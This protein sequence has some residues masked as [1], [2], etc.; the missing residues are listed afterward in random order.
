M[1]N[2]KLTEVPKTAAYLVFQDQTLDDLMLEGKSLQTSRF[3]RLGL[4]D[5][6]IEECSLTQSL[7]ED[8]YLRKASFVNVRLTGSTFRNCNLEKATFRGC[9]LRYCTFQ[10]TRLTRDEIIGCLPVEPN[11]RLQLARNLR[12]NFEAL[13]DKASADAVLDIEIR[14]QEQELL[15]AFRRKTEYYR[16]HYTGVDQAVAGLRYLLSNLNGLVWGYGHR[17]RRLIASFA[18]LTLVFC[19][20]TYFGDVHYN[21]PTESSSRSLSFW[22]SVYQASAATVRA[23]ATAFSPASWGGRALQVLEGFTGTLL[24]ALLAA[25][26]YRRIA[27]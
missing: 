1:K 10:N 4:K 8:C 2:G 27:R 24:L 26:S 20:I 5:A 13:G 6:R 3:L 7:F 25:A 9:D 23:G 19:L 21:V 15:E 12:K 16:A 17:V 18:V 22:E 14:A 11:L